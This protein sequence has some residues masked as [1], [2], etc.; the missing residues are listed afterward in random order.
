MGEIERDNV[1][2]FP[3]DVMPDV[4]FGPVGKGEHTHVLAFMDSRII[5][6][7]QFRPL[8]FGIP[9]TVPIAEG[10]NS[11]FGAG[12]FLVTTRPTEGRIDVVVLQDLK[13]SFRF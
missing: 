9:L 1:Q 8:V 13:Q 2:V 6:I 12:A 11:F 10:V 3:F 7:P 4:E 5:K